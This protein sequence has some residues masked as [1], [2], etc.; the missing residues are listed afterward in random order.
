VS[1][2]RVELD[3]PRCVAAGQ[4]A[5]TAPEVF[6]QRDDD[7]VS[8]VLDAEPHPDLHETVREAAALCPAEAIRVV[9]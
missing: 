2:L 8:V 6:D 3:E 4:C 1:G 9:E 7:G 5:M